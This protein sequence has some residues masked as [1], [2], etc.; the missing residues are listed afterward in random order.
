MESFLSDMI[1]E[2]KPLSMLNGMV[3]KGTVRR[4]KGA[5]TMNDAAVLLQKK[6]GL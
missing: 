4:D 6:T 3:Q 2:Q 5:L 1:G